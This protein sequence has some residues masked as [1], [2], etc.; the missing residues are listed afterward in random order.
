MEVFFIIEAV[1]VG[2]FAVFL[3]VAGIWQLVCPKRQ[4]IDPRGDKIVIYEMQS[5]FNIKDIPPKEQKL[6][7][8]QSLRPNRKVI[9][10]GK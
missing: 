8:G 6:P 10:K 5:Y 4:K 9:K 7:K 3:I 2:V 1:L